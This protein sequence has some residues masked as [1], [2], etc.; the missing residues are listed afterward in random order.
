MLVY[1][2]TNIP[3]GME[4]E[5]AREK[6]ISRTQAYAQIARA[7]KV[8]LEPIGRTTLM[9]RP[10]DALQIAAAAGASNVGIVMD[11]FHFYRA[12]VTD[13]TPYPL[14]DFLMV[15][16]NDA[17]DLP[18]EKLTDA[19]RVH[20][21]LGIL[22]LA[23]YRD[24]LAAKN[25]SGFL[26]IG[27]LPARV[28]GTTGEPSCYRCEDFV[29]QI[30]RHRLTMKIAFYTSTLGDQP[31]QEVIRWAKAA[32]FDGIELD[33]N[34]HLSGPERAEKL[35]EQARDC[36]IE[37]PSIILFGNLLH[38]DP[39]ERKEIRTRAHSIAHTAIDAKVPVLVLFAGR[40]ETTDEESNYQD[41]AGFLNELALLRTDG[42][43]RIA[44]ENWPGVNKNFVATTPQGWEKLFSSIKQ[45]NVGLEF[46]PSHL[47]WQGI[48]PY[49]AATE[50]R[51]RIFLLHGK[52]TKLFPERVQSV[53][54]CGNWW[55][56]R[57]P[58]R[59]ELDWKQ[60]L[61]FARTK[62][63]FDG[64]VSIEHEDREFAWPNGDVETRKK[65][66]AYGLSQLR[67]AIK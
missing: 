16:V 25:Y 52:D 11:T 66:L 31:A 49:Q 43:F 27:D 44:L 19:N 4:P 45:W 38:S 60:F 26:S 14:N 47:L 40:N 7:L 67:E 22:P 10:E 8:G 15:H 48:D 61:T 62:L 39:V 32:G 21:G 1:C 42:S 17:E 55:E 57:L 2:A 64:Y 41:I 36:G 53:G 63:G 29:R 30:V 46:D 13:I 35:I 65:G 28:L 12:G 9:G 37:V 34:R 54:Y 6:A 5:K 20:L 18:V 23:Q 50:F 51:D 3:A 24:A 59:G 33:V 58:G 56:Y